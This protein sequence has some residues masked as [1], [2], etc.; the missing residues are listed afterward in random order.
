MK[1]KGRKQ[2]RE[3]ERE[4]GVPGAG[5]VQGG[6]P[7]EMHKFNVQ[8]MAEGVPPQEMHK[9]NVQKMAEEVPPQEMHK[10]NVQKF[11]TKQTGKVVKEDILI[12]G[13]RVVQNGEKYS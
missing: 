10:F 1:K 4:C 5:N 11:Q 9:F 2:K 8:K 12:T 7:Q 6:T 13:Q 3:R